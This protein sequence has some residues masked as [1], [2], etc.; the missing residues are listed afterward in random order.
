MFNKKGAE[1]SLNTIIIAIIVIIVLVAVVFF[2]LYGFKG[3]TDKIKGIF[4]QGTAGTDRSLA[5]QFCNQYCD[6]AKEEQRTNSQKFIASDS[7]Y[8]KKEFDILDPTTS[9]VKSG[10]HCNELISCTVSC[11]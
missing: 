2:F 11:A 7:A 5:I 4:F 1:I 6:A 9:V 3:T 10:V 8:C